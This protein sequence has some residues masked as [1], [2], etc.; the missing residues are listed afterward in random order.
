MNEKVGGQEWKDKTGRWEEGVQ[1]KE[2]EEGQLKL[3]AILG[4]IWKPN[5]V[6]AS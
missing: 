4:V 5:I 3:M 6:E 1:V 2:Y